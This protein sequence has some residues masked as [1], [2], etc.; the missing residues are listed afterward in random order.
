MYKRFVAFVEQSFQR[1]LLGFHILLVSLTTLFLFFYL[2]NN[3]RRITDFSLGENK[4]GITQ[5]VEEYLTI[6]A[7]EKAT[8][9]WLQLAAAQ[10]NLT[11][12][13]RTAQKVVDDYDV[14]AGD[15]AVYTLPL[16]QTQLVE[17]RGAW[18]TAADAEVDALIP[19]PIADNADARELLTVS[20]LLNLNMD[21]IF[22]ADDNNTLIYFVG[23]ADTP[24]T[25]AYP[26]V[27]LV[28]VL[29]DAVSFLF[30]RDFFPDNVA[31]WQR[32][33]T[34][35]ALQARTPNP[36]TVEAPYGDAAG[37]GTVM[38]MFYPLWDGR[39][40]EFAG[41]VG[42]DLSLDKIIEDVLSI[43]V[44]ETGFAFLV[45]SRG[46]AIAM[47]PQG[48]D[49][50]G[51][52]QT[53]I[54]HGGLSFNSGLMS[55]AGE[56]AVQDLSATLQT[57][58]EGIYQLHLTAD[59]SSHLV[60]FASLPPL[61]NNQYEEDVWKIGIVVPE[62]EILQ[63][64]TETETAVTDRSGQINAISIALV[65]AFLLIAMFVSAQFSNNVTRD[66]RNLSEAAQKVADKQYDTDLTIKS[67]DE[68]GQLGQTFNAMTQEIR[69][70][71]T[72]LEGLVAER[73]EDL[74]RANAEITHL[75]EKLKDE[76]LRLS[77]EL[78]VARQL[79]MMVLPPESET[80]AIP[81]L[82]IAC[83]M[84]PADEVGGD[85]YDVLQVGDS[86]YLTIGD[87]TGHG[88]SSGVVMLMAQTAFLTLSQS[89]EYSIDHILAS[90]NQVLYRN[91]LRIHENKNM[92]LAVIQYDQEKFSIVGQHETVVICRKDGV[93]EVI[94]TIDLGL[95]VGLEEDITEFIGSQQFRLTPG[96]VMLLYTDGI[97]EAE[98]GNRQY[99]GMDKL[100]DLL[101]QYHDLDA[102]AIVDGIIKD[103]YAFIG[104]A[105][106]YDDITMMVIKQK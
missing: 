41:A 78:D 35:A 70:Y 22:D 9:T 2:T 83:Y 8:S 28:E 36:I 85:Y 21:A 1:K 94:D 92:T 5:T 4:R 17:E 79:Q 74:Q 31:V 53:L 106:V 37:Q 99:F 62:A 59:D 34:D 72:N 58:A 24:V 96:D 12:L 95:P 46:E 68:I 33:Y 50:L 18:T 54:D 77:A 86:T 98:N 69:A 25:R 44:A 64:I 60:A 19:P 82:D 6:Y 27:H 10:D 56:T 51:I 76:N 7:Q 91:I 102:K 49:L 15:T 80:R 97:T 20:A 14:L 88:L 71:T 90:L 103:V 55:A 23:N 66:L 32:W 52:E 93:V 105:P 16:F 11:V 67:R 48:Y 87:V 3:F 40:N 26:N 89:G 63:L 43:R 42:L 104:T 57:Q 13:G 45:N 30:W 75:N 39:K 101:V 61:S 29:G 84:E 38:T 100:T 65:A 73:T 81:D 47:P